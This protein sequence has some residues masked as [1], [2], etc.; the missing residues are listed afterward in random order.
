MRGL[1][2][3]SVAY[4]KDTGE[5]VKTMSN[6]S[7]RRTAGS[8]HS[9]GYR[10]TR[11]DSK[12]VHVHRLAFFL[13]EGAWPECQVDHINGDRSD[14]RWCNL[15]KVDQVTNMQNIRK[16]TAAS[17]SGMLGAFTAGRR[18]RSQIKVHGRLVNL[19]VFDTAAE[20]HAAYTAAK[21]HY[22]EGCTI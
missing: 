15:R 17:S 12:V 7:Q 9:A 8:V 16:A 13:T 22:H 3:V 11:F 2:L 6:G 4:D 14:N 18:W 19:G 10:V 21:R 1:A 5:I 20:A